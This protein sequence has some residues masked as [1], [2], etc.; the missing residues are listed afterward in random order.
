MK[1]LM[2]IIGVLLMAGIFAFPMASVAQG[3]NT[4]KNTGKWSGMQ[5]G[6]GQMGN[7]GNKSTLTDEQQGQIEKL[8]EKFREDNADIIKELMT[9][10]FDL[11]TVLSSD[12]PDAE[13]AKALQKEISE[14]N[15]RLA[16][17]RIDLQLEL[18]KIAPD[19]NFGRGMGRG[20]GMMGMTGAE[21]GI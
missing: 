20:M 3:P 13:K 7:T 8:Q 12:N 4:G 17:E 2:S 10:R 18:N 6:R 14:L 11:N 15:A 5:R 21:A 19:A 16:Q 9:K 1:R